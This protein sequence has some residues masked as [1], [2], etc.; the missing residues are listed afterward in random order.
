MFF[1]MTGPGQSLFLE[2]WMTGLGN[3]WLFVWGAAFLWSS[4]LPEDLT[5]SL[6][7][8]SLSTL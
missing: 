1:P 5:P 7:P 6:V 4:S 8:V 2:E 3:S